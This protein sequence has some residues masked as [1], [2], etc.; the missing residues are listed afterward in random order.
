MMSIWIFRTLNCVGIHRTEMKWEKKWPVEVTEIHRISNI[1]TF[2]IFS[3]LEQLTKTFIQKKKIQLHYWN[4]F[5]WYFFTLVERS[6][7]EMGE[8]KASV[9]QLIIYSTNEYIALAFPSVTTYFNIKWSRSIEMP[10]AEVNYQ[11][12]FSQIQL[13]LSHF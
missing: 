7:I 11:N 2:F 5:F 12:I 9:R 10:A 13:N 3:K 8:Q 4:S 6:T 1:D